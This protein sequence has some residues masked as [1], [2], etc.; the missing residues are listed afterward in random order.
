[1]GYEEA[2]FWLG[3]LS[4]LA[5]LIRILFYFHKFFKLFVWSR[6]CKQ[7]DLKSFGKWAVV[8]G[9]TDGIGKAYAIELAKRGM[10]IILISRNETKLTNTALE[11]EK[12]HGVKTFWIK[13]DFSTRDCYGHIE[14]NLDDK[15]IGILVNNVGT[16][17]FVSQEY[18]EIEK[19]SLWKEIDINCGALAMMTRIVLPKMKQKR[20]GLIVN[21]SSISSITTFPTMSLYAATKS[22]MNMFSVSIEVEVAPYNIRVQN[23]IPYF[24]ETKLLQEGEEVIQNLKRKAKFMI[25]DAETYAKSAIYTLN[26]DYLM[27]TGY[28]PHVIME[29]AANVLSIRMSAKILHNRLQS[30]FGKKLKKDSNKAKTI[31]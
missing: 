7:I 10:D 1:M 29:L 16:L 26:T 5:L 15:D 12:S 19:E 20:K 25:P 3:V 28:W 27:T 30:M 24:I 14:K 31:S 2:F 13:A 8:T 22:F 11:I 9:A 23:L 18:N 21:M 6:W 4:C 17:Q